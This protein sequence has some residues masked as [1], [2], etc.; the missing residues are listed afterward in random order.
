MPSNGLPAATPGASADK[1]IPGARLALIMLLCIN[2]FN[3][4]DRQVLAAV[5]PEIRND[6]LAG[7]PYAEDKS[8]WLSTA[9]LVAYMVLA[10]LFGYLGDRTSRWLLIGIGVL[11]W[12]LASGAS[13]LAATFVLLLLTRCIVGV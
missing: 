13:G 8:G 6:L 2:L 4:L 5:E 11:V 1:R 3:Y 9:F 7:D 10:P 12:S